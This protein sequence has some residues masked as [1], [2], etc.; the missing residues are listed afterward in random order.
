MVQR[1]PRGNLRVRFDSNTHICLNRVN[2]EAENSF[3]RRV[4]M[5]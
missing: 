4:I 3:R 2:F 1:K 5:P